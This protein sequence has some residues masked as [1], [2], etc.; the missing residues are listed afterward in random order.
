MLSSRYLKKVSSIE[1]RKTKEKKNGKT[2]AIIIL[3]FL[4]V[5]PNKIYTNL[6]S[7]TKY[8]NK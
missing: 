3:F 4:K 2:K 8:T 7:R 1:L 6:V 5:S